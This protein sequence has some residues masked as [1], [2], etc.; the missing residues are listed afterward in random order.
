MATTTAGHGLGAPGTEGPDGGAPDRLEQLTAAGWVLPTGVPGLLG[1]TAKFE[2]VLTRLQTELTAVDPSA[3][4]GPAWYPPVVPRA[5]IDRA[6]YAESFPQLLGTVHALQVGGASE[7]GRA[8]D[9]APGSRAETDVV[10]APAVCYSVYPQIA[11]GTIE[12]ARFFDA[13]GHCYRHEATSEYGRF[14]AFRMREFVV[15]A[16]QDEAW[17]WRDAWIARCEA[18]F[19]RLGLK[20]AVEV[21]SDPFFGPGD[22]FM[23]SSQLQQNLKYEFHAPVRDGD[24]GTAIA[25]ANCHKEHLGER[26]AIDF[27]GEGPAHSSCMAFG[28]ERTLSALI[29]A[30]GDNLDDWP[31]FG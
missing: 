23:R 21:A 6:E 5:N 30:H 18:L 1:F 14:R 24:P 7:E 19:A 27:A 29:H 26:F 11:D 31:D 8:A 13:V 25:S 4:S 10:L 3:S 9:R 12:E 20:V 22:R 28:L 17:E 15:V 16:G 2:S